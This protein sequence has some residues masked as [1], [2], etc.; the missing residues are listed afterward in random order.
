MRNVK[1]YKNGV[2]SGT[3]NGVDSGLNENKNKIL[4]AIKANPSAT[5]K[6]ISISLNIPFRNMQRYF[7]I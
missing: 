3:I 6:D 7:Q 2:I 1:I 5:A 4:N